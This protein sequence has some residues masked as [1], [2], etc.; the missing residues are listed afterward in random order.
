MTIL[1]AT[2]EIPP[3]NSIDTR[4]KTITT[5]IAYEARQGLEQL[6]DGDVLEVL[7]EDFD[8]IEGDLQAW[9]RMTGHKLVRT[10][11]ADGLQRHLIEKGPAPREAARELAFVVSDPGLFEL[12]S[13]LGFALAAALEGMHVS[14]YF[15]AEAVKVLA[16]D[17]EAKAHGRYRPISRFARK[18]LADAGH[19]PAQ[20]KLRQLHELG[21]T[22]Y[23]CGPSMEH[24]GVSKA[25]LAFDDVV[26]SEYLTFMEVMDKADIRF[27]IQ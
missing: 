18:G 7:T 25:D 15:Q 4:P 9:C 19:Y 10:E 12:L 26:I 2:T 6:G 22:F 16:K 3:K 14:I 13:P 17:F 1:D 11:A 24:F 21:A 5:A 8:P 23:A 20:E 27:F